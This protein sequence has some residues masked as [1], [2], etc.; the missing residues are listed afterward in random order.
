M[1]EIEIHTHR[2][3]TN[4]SFVDTFSQTTIYLFFK[5]EK[6]FLVSKETFYINYQN[7]NNSVSLPYYHKAVYTFVYQ[8]PL[9]IH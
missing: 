3:K 7:N 9:I 6:E 8:L 1:C 4:K 5:K 2:F